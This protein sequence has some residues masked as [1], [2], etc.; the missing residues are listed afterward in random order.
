[1]TNWA[2]SHNE[3]N[4]IQN[5]LTI[6][7]F[8]FFKCIKFRVVIDKAYIKQSQVDRVP[9]CMVYVALISAVGLKLKTSFIVYF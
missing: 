8:M 3:Y 5:I 1:M 2:W 6:A 9:R 4:F 7:S